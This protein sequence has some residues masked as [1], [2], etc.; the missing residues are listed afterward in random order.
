MAEIRDF[1]RRLMARAGA[2]Y[3]A[4]LG[5]PLLPALACL[6]ALLCA[7]AAPATPPSATNTTE[8]A[9]GTVPSG[10]VPAGTNAVANPSTGI[11]SAQ[12]RMVK[13]YGAGGF[14]GLEAYQS[15]FL[16]SADG[17]ILTAWSYVLDT[18]YLAVMLADGRKLE[19]KLVGADPRLEIAV[20]K[21]DAQSLDHFD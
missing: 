14:E 7:A 21:I 17:H 13:L 15:G 9:A 6:V 20:L 11:D 2:V 5:G 8:P 19:A 1:A 10:T 3:R 18:D 12:P 16:V 4:P